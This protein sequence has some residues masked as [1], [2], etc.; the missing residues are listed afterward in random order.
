MFSVFIHRFFLWRK[1][2][3]SK[4]IFQFA[5]Y[6][7]KSKQLFNNII[8]RNTCGLFTFQKQLLILETMQS[9]LKEFLNTNMIMFSG[10][11]DAN[12]FK[13]RY[14]FA[15]FAVKCVRTS[16]A[17]KTQMICG[18]LWLDMLLTVA[19]STLAGFSPNY[20]QIQIWLSRNPE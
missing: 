13:I 12:N 9:E 16:K 15:S 10:H 19:Y 5:P 8:K 4:Q 20:A 1:Y 14:S 11:L 17:R 3:S 2:Q 6:V 7:C 18:L